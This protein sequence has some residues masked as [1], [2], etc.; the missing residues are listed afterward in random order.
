MVNV[1]VNEMED[2]GCIL[3]PTCHNVID[4]R[5]FSNFGYEVLEGIINEKS[6]LVSVLIKC[7]FCGT[8]I[9][10]NLKEVLSCGKRRRT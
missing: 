10:V 2:D 8:E 7:H 3:C 9:N 6:E 5:D 1:S 4:P